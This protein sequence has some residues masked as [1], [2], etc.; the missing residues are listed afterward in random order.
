MEKTKVM[1]YFGF[2]GDI[3]PLEEITAA[4][5]IEPTE[6]YTIGDLVIREPHPSL[7]ST[8]KLYRK[9]TAWKFGTD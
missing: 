5:Q 1:A 6:A 3:F 7:D 8:R 2:Y 9:F 4:L